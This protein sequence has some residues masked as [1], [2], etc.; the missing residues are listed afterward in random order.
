MATKKTAKKTTAKK[1][2]AKKT[3]AKKVKTVK[4]NPTLPPSMP[5]TANDV[6]KI[7]LDSINADLD[8]NAREDYKDIDLLANSIKDSGLIQPLVVTKD[9]GDRYFLVAGFRR[10]KA[11]QLIGHSPVNATVIVCHTKDASNKGLLLANWAENMARHNLTSYEM[12]KRF[13]ALKMHHKI[14][15]AMLANAVQM[16]KAHVNSLM[17]C[18]KVLCDEIMAEWK[19]G[20]PLLTTDNLR[21]ISRKKEDEDQLKVWT[22]LKGGKGKDKEDK[23]PEDAKQ[24]PRL[25]E[26]DNEGKESKGKDK[27]GMKDRATI[28]STIKM[29]EETHKQ[30]PMTKAVIQTLNW[31]VKREASLPSLPKSK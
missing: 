7:P 14:S 27:E 31:V 24:E 6:I 1:T 16:G 18:F 2:T 11:C 19:K 9:E 15:G 25:D 8:F 10:F 22:A 26:K 23:K 13:H 5:S 28:L 20:N 21:A 30:T 12:A 3:T 17:R 4:L 29:L